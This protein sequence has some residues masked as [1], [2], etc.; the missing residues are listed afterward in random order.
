MSRVFNIVLMVLTF[1]AFLAAPVFAHNQAVVI[2]LGGKSASLQG[3]QYLN[4]SFADFAPVNET[5]DYLKPWNVVLIIPAASKG[6]LYNE[7]GAAMGFY[8]APV[9]LPKK[10]VVS[11][12]TAYAS[13]GTVTGFFMRKD[14]AT[15]EEPSS[16]A[17]VQNVFTTYDSATEPVQYEVIDNENYTYFVSLLLQ[18]DAKLYSIRV[19]YT[20]P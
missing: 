3:A 9:H 19:K 5:I 10:A 11:E 14:L 17:V 2:P 18:N 4:L 8:D 13:D 1:V 6:Y 12:I 16:I 15:A 20:I 7:G